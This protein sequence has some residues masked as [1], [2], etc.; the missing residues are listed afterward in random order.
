MLIKPGNTRIRNDMYYGII[1][2]L[3]WSFVQIEI[4]GYRWYEL[5]VFIGYWIRR[6]SMVNGKVSLNCKICESMK[7]KS[8]KCFNNIK[9]YHQPPSLYH[10]SRLT[11]GVLWKYKNIRGEST[12]NGEMATNNVNASLRTLVLK[13]IEWV[14]NHKNF[15]LTARF[16]LTPELYIW[17][18]TV[19]IIQYFF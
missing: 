12:W 17:V 16:I 8:W 19:F 6:A 15:W 5:N 14:K 18:I 7:I 11:G 4:E 2:I 10:F 3:C 9:P 13:L 1:K